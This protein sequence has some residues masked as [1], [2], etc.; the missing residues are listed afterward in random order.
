MIKP[1]SGILNYDDHSIGASGEFDTRL[2][3]RNALGA[4][5]FV[6]D[7]VHQEQTTTFSTL[8]VPSTTPSQKD[9]DLQSSFAVQ[10]AITVVTNVRATLG[11]RADHLGGLQA[12]DLNSAKTAVVPFQVQGVCP[13]A[14]PSSFRSCTDHVW[15][16]NPAGALS[17]S[18]AKLGTLFVTF[19]EKSRFPTL[20]DRYSYKAVKAVPNPA[21]RPEQPS[22]TH[23]LVCLHPKT[24]E[25]ILYISPGNT[26]RILGLNARERG[27][28]SGADQSPGRARESVCPQMECRRFA[29]LG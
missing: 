4:S 16:Y 29:D 8:N 18:T 13:A 17:Y 5:F 7:A 2:I 10:D 1:S 24:G 15:S 14:N 19:A 20:K 23:P 25:R 3:S 6:N 22:A 12:Q 9:S 11:F 27:A 21:L 26:D 28:I